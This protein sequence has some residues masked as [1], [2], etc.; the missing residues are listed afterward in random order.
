MYAV[1]ISLSMRAITSLH[2]PFRA[3]L[4]SFG[5]VQMTLR[6]QFGASFKMV[7]WYLVR[8][9]WDGCKC[10][11]LRG[12][13]EIIRGLPKVKVVNTSISQMRS[14][15]HAFSRV[16]LTALWSERATKWLR[17]W[18]L[19]SGWPGWNPS[20]ATTPLRDIAQLTYPFWGLI[21]S[22]IRWG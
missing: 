22:S 18:V 20:S 15:Q 11:H 8:V 5:S 6:R 13:F 16:H 2:L 14:S 4:S 12:I 7:S 10:S 9:A 17:W 1:Q 3:F 21:S 19:K